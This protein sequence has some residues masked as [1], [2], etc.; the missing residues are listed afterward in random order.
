MGSLGFGKSN[1][2]LKPNLK[3]FTT[4]EAFECGRK[5]FFYNNPPYP[6]LS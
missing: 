1:D 5:N 6:I 2:E 3:S 4:R